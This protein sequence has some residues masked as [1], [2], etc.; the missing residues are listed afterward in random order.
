MTIA[1]IAA[2]GALLLL[3]VGLALVARRRGSRLRAALARTRDEATSEALVTEDTRQR[4]AV[5]TAG[6]REAAW[7][8]RTAAGRNIS[9]TDAVTGLEDRLHAATDRAGDLERSVADLSRDLLTSEETLAETSAVAES[10]GARAAALEVD[11]A[12][13]RGVIVQVRAELEAVRATVA[14]PAAPPSEVVSDPEGLRSRLHGALAEVDRLRDRISALETTLALTKAPA[15]PDL[16]P[17]DPWDSN[18]QLA[19]RDSS[20]ARLAAEL[21]LSRTAA[22][23]SRIELDRL[24]AE[25]AAV[26]ADA[27]DRVAAAVATLSFPE[28]APHQAPADPS[29]RLVAREAEVRDL[30][31][32]LATLGATR[33]AELK[34]LNERIAS[35][36]RLYLDLDVRDARIVEL[37]TELKQATEMLDSVRADAG[38]LEERFAAA[39]TEVTAA[40]RVEATAT[41]LSVQLDEARRRLADLETE[42]LRS[43]STDDEISQLRTLLAAERDRNLRLERRASTETGSADISRAVAAAT[44]PLQETITRLE[45]ELASRHAPPPPPPPPST[46]DDVRLIRGIGPKIAGILAAN[47]INSLRQIATFT[48]AD[49]DR[50]GPLL[51]VYPGRIHDDR[52]VEQARELI[53][54]IA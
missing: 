30:E 27:D 50:I 17:A 22:A 48:A 4:L 52:W 41:A 44:F 53:G 21:E 29:P 11:L 3:I 19:A 10:A 28:A 26:R 38:R 31:Q 45:R 23:A 15:Q 18:R 13:A 51:P 46:P 43:R 39:Q 36:E 2:G 24:G 40:R 34:R 8:A 9:L 7:A 1:T 32:R 33:N 16:L 54:E 35:L 6:E 47:G 12:A 5:T 37:E 14:V 20:I 25:L 42:S 49:I